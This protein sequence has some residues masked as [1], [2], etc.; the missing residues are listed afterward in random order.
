VVD[1][2]GFDAVLQSPTNLVWLLSRT[3][4]KYYFNEIDL[5]IAHSIYKTFT[6]TQTVPSSPKKDVSSLIPSDTNASD[7][8]YFWKVLGN[9]VAFSP[10]ANLSELAPFAPIGLSASGFNTSQISPQFAT[11]LAQVASGTDTQLKQLTLSDPVAAVKTPVSL[12]VVNNN[13]LTFPSL[14]RFG[15]NYYFRASIAATAI[16][17]NLHEDAVYY[18]GRLDNTGTVLKGSMSYTIDFP[19]DVPANAFWSVT[20]YYGANGSLIQNPAGIYAVGAHSPDLVKNSAGFYRI[21]LQTNKPS[22]KDV[23]WLPTPATAEF[24]LIARF[25]QPR[26]EVVNNSWP[27]PWIVPVA[28][29][30]LYSAGS[31]VQV[32]VSMAVLFIAL[33][34]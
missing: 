12:S 32:S 15:T 28:G 1:E 31:I 7:P 5:A 22:Q 20:A 16:A 34:L 17:G 30:G 13:W 2:S 33:L 23:N 14:G 10:P 18:N 21:Q 4:V 25:Y 3:E 26:L 6:L 27:V 29:T 8:L 9:L 24:Y 19:A 11:I